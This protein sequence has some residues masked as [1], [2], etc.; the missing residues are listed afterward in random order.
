MK[1]RTIEKLTRRPQQR[2]LSQLR[3]HGFHLALGVEIAGAAGGG[4]AVGE[5]RFGFCDSVGAG[6]GLGG[7]EVAGGV[8]RT[9]FEQDGEF[10]EGAIEVALIG[11][12]ERE[13]VAGEGVIWI[14]GEDVVEGG[15]AIHGQFS[16]LSSQKDESTTS[17]CFRRRLLVLE[18][19][20]GHQIVVAVVHFVSRMVGQQI[21]RVAS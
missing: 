13:P 1:R 18:E 6:Q 15:D 2:T 5:H 8:V 14:L 12:F 4:D 9:V 20:L 17:G 7:H 19:I 11:V 10:G 21:L 3:Q 16:V